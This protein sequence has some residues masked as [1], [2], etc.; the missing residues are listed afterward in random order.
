MVLIVCVAIPTLVEEPL[1]VEVLVPEPELGEEHKRVQARAQELEPE[2]V[3][4][5]GLARVLE[6]ERVLALVRELMRG[7]VL[8]LVLE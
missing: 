5:L 6:P 1:E 7:L 2:L 8:E 4:A 3:L